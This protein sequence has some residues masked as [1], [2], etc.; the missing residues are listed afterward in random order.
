[1]AYAKNV[2]KQI[3][4]CYQI[5]AKQIKPLPPEHQIFTI[6]T[7]GKILFAIVGTSM[8]TF[9]INRYLK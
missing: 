3:L 4:E 6:H 2:D 1:M 7:S 5:F 9:V 8:A